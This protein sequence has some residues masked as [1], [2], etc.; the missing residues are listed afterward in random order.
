VAILETTFNQKIAWS[1]FS[2][3][4]CKMRQKSALFTAPRMEIKSALPAA[5]QEKRA[6]N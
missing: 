5:G 1:V 6:D 3:K 2:Q 4:P